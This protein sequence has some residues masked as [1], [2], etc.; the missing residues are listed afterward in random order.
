[1]DVTSTSQT[2]KFATEYS[3]ALRCNKS[4]LSEFI[5]CFFGFSHR[6]CYFRTCFSEKCFEISSYQSHPN[7]NNADNRNDNQRILDG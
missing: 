1:M 3:V 5:F 2:P 7:S 4:R 6:T